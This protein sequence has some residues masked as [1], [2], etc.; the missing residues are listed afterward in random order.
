MKKGTKIAL[1][2]SLIYCGLATYAL[3][4]TIISSTS[5][6]L[7]WNST[8]FFPGYFLGFILGYSGGTPFVILGQLITFIIL[9]FLLKIVFNWIE[10]ESQNLID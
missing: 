9:F 3:N 10:Y 4:T 1:F 6:S 5:D 2:V 7:F 8:V